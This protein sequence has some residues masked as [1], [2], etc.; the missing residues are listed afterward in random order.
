M[1]TGVG[2]GI[3]SESLGISKSIRLPDHSS[4]FQAEVLAVTTAARESAVRAIPQEGITF[5]IDSQAAIKAITATEI[6]SKLV[7]CCREELKVLGTQHKV[8]LYWVPGH[9][10]IPGNEKADELARE[11]SAAVLRQTEPLVNI[12]LCALKLE[13]GK[14]AT[15]E[16]NT[17]W[18]LLGFLC[19]HK[20]TM[21]VL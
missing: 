10:G 5:F 16:A 9:E 19:N 21:A 7:K 13:V 4:V 2:S 6:K 11:G 1:D 14:I 20:E 17:R 18:D 8:S 12:P 3:F 15:Q